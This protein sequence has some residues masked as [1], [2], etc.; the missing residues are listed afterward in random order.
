MVIRADEFPNLRASSYKIKSPES[1]DYNCIAWA[2]GDVTAWWWPDF[3]ETVYWPPGVPR[4]ETLEAFIQAYRTLGYEPCQDT[5]FEQGFEK[6]ALYSLTD[7]EMTHAAR[8]L[9]NGRWT[10][11][12]GPLEDIEHENPEDVNGPVYGSV[13]CV[14][15]RSRRVS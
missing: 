2:A 1:R 3:L 5:S 9:D 6:V 11:K 4:E 7:G 8:Q 12:L 10:S 13:I 14:L 15:R